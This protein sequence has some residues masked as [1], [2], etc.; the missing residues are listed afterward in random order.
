MLVQADGR[1]PAASWPS[2]KTSTTL[3]SSTPNLM[4]VPSVERSPAVTALGLKPRPM[5]GV[6]A[7]GDADLP[8]AEAG[9]PDLAHQ[10][11]L[12]RPRRC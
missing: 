1:E 7:D 11:E 12:L 3:R 10:L 8:A 5:P 2:R 6:P 9:V 4:G